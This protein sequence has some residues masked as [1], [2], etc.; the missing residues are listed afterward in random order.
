MFANRLQPRKLCW[1]CPCHYELCSCCSCCS[2]CCCCYRCWG[3][4]TTTETS[5]TSTLRHSHTDT[6]STVIFVYKAQPG[7]KK[8]KHAHTHTHTERQ[9]RRAVSARIF[10]PCRFSNERTALGQLSTSTDLARSPRCCAGASFSLWRQAPVARQCWLTL[11][12]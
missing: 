3:L 8:P 4:L 11:R 1:I 7:K 12:M 5:H 9:T 10:R 2:Y 6:T